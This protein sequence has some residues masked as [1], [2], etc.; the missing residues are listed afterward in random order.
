MS[1]KGVMMELTRARAAPLGKAARSGARTRP[2][3]CPTRGAAP[4]L[5]RSRQVPLNSS[6]ASASLLTASLGETIRRLRPTRQIIRK[7]SL[8]LRLRV[9]T[10]LVQMVPLIGAKMNLKWSLFK[11]CT[12]SSMLYSNVLSKVNKVCA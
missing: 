11:T 3:S 9:K 4:P 2:W 12:I 5:F 8:N 1:Q 10:V 7:K 6:T